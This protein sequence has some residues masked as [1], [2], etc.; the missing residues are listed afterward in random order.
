[1][2]G[3]SGVGVG[4]V[5]AAVAVVALTWLWAALVHLVWRPYSAARAFELQGVRGPAYRFFVGNNKEAKAMRAATSGETLDLRSHDFISRVFLSWNGPRPA[6][7]AGNYDMVKRILSDRSGLYAKPD[8]GPDIMALLGM[9]LVFTEGD[10]WARH[11]RVVHPAFAMDKLKAMTGTMAACAAEVIRS[12]EARAQA[13]GDKVT[14]VEV[15]QQ[16]TELTAD[17]IS[18]TAFGSSYRQ[19]KEVFLAQRELQFIAFASINNVRVPGSQYAPTKANVRR[20]QLER[21]YQSTE[22][23]GMKPYEFPG[24]CEVL[25]RSDRAKLQLSFLLCKTFQ[26]YHDNLKVAE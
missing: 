10:D 23:E 9:G 4:M 18:H 20:W 16:F 13:K 6:L 21:K 3:G 5:A 26:F 24:A 17:V 19:G 2:G 1:M 12:W 14:T 8:P 7:C 25:Y 11:R 22:Q 15:G